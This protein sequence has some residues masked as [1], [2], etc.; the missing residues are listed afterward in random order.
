M[1]RGM[2]SANVTASQSQCVYPLM[3][4]K[5]ELDSGTLY[6]TDGIGTVGFDGQTW[7]GLG[8]LLDMG[9]M[10]ESDDR[11]A[12]RVWF[13]LNG[14]DPD[15]LAAFYA[16]SVYKRAI[17]VY[18]AFTDDAGDLVDDP[19][20]RW[21]GYGDTWE[22]DVGG[23]FDSITLFAED[24]RIRDSRPNGLLWTDEDQQKL[25][26]GDTGYQFIHQII[27]ARVTWG[28]DGNP[29]NFGQPQAV[30]SLSAVETVRR[31]RRIFG[32]DYYP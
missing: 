11:T 14:T 10:E 32:F 5:I 31:S 6:L 16:E 4:V 12:Y 7:N 19:E 15:L 24:E 1:S 9:P 13:R 29:V 30:H 3:L 21:S 18:L 17:T 25:Y 8:G 26:V 27:D 2:A 28:P 22:A 20:L 23:E